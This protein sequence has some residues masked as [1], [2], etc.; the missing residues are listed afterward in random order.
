MVMIVILLKL[1]LAFQ[2]D[3]DFQ[4]FSPPHDGH[5]QVAIIFQELVDVLRC[6]D[7]TAVDVGDDVTGP[8]TGPVCRRVLDHPKDKDSL[9]DF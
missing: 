8:E 3:K 2:I 5:V 6:G 7:G 1:L 4:D 9:R